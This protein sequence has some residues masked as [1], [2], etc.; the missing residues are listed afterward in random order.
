MVKNE[1]KD[2]DEARAKALATKN[3]KVKNELKDSGEAKAKAKALAQE[4]TTTPAAGALDE[5]ET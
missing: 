2:L 5:E 4:S 3:M 1:L